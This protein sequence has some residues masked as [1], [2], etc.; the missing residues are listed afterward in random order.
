MPGKRHPPPGVPPPWAADET[1]VYH[2]TDVGNLDS[3]IDA[4]CIHCDEGCASLKSAPVSI[5]Y[6]DLKA[7]RAVTVVEV[8]AGGTLANYV[9]F[10]FAPRSPMLYTIHRGN[11]AGATQEN[12]VHLVFCLEDLAEPDQFVITDGHAIKSLTDQFGTLDDLEAVD[13][14]IMRETY[15]A[16]TDEDGDRS[17]RRQAEFLVHERVAFSSVRQ[18]VAMNRATAQQAKDALSAIED[19]PPIFIRPNWYY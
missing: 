7:K 13:W 10:Y 9:P 16:D 8:A 15:W 3:M 12:I 6:T 17:R 2:I 19:P 14:D 4:G 1:A 18:I 11:V 5:A